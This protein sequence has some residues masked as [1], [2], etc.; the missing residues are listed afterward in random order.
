MKYPLASPALVGT[1]ALL[2]LSPAHGAWMSF[3][4]DG[5][6][7]PRLAAQGSPES[8]AVEVEVPGLELAEDGEYLL[9]RLP[10]HARRLVLGEPEL[11]LISTSVLLPDQGTPRATLVV[12]EEETL[13]LDRKVAPSRGH[14]ARDIPVSQVPRIEG[15]VYRAAGPYPAA[16]YAVEMGTPYLLRDVRGAAVRVSPMIYT[17]ATGE[18]RVLRRF[19]IEVEVG[20]GGVTVNEKT[21]E[22]PGVTREFLELYRSLFVNLPG[23]PVIDPTSEVT[24]GGLILSPRKWFDSLAPLQAW[25]HEKGFASELVPLDEAGTTADEIKAFLQTR[26]D[27]GGLAYVLLVGDADELPTLKG[28]KEGAD[29]DACY[30]KLE[31]ADHVPDLFVSRF[32]ATTTAEVDVQVARAITYE[33]AP[34]L[35]DLAAGYRRATG[36]ASAEGS[37]TDSERMDIVREALLGFRYD[38]MDQLYDKGGWFGSKVKPAQVV[39]AVNAGRGLIAYMGHGSKTAW[40]TSKFGTSHAKALGNTSI[41]PVIF[42]VACVNGDFVGGGDCFAEAWAKAGTASSPRGAIGMVAASTNMSWDPPV[43]WQR[44]IIAEYLIPE[45]AFTGGAL[46]HFGLV[47]AME[48]WGDDASSEGVMMVEQCVYFGDS[49]VVLRNDV[50]RQADVSVVV[51]EETGARSLHVTAGGQ[52]VRAAR[53]VI[54]LGENRWVGTTDEAGAYP[55]PELREDE[56]PPPAPATMLTVT[57]ANL[58]PVLH[59][60]F[61]LGWGADPGDG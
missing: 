30:G 29:C 60:S 13:T 48:Q 42:D 14:F 19:R 4:A 7:A 52:P 11:P 58:I 40:V 33:K 50:P 34:V 35:G 41:W 21:R 10:G 18:L 5:A 61:D 46:H 45:K 2:L 38:A 20:A 44:N 56:E 37:P 25:R 59:Q 8:F 16:D 47:K 27:L 53:I 17:P 54:E 6:A 55:V 49:S 24:G 51:D 1:L 39:A 23:H 31:G 22:R 32:S 28:E 3:G 26:Y 15:P 57:G 9:P 36:I 43:D 12:L